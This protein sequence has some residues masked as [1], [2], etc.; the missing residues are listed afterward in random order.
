MAFTTFDTD[1]ENIQKLGDKP[2]DANGL[3]AYELKVLFDKAAV[4]LKAFI[5]TIMLPEIFDAV[6]AAARGVTQEGLSGTTIRDGTIYDSKLSKETGNQAVSTDTVQDKAITM[7]KLSSQIQTM[8]TNF[9]TAI[10]TISRTLDQKAAVSS[11]ATVATS[12]QYKDLSGTPTIP[13]IDSELSETSTNAVQNNLIFAALA[14]KA[15]IEALADVATSGQ[16]DDLSGK[17][18]IPVVDSALSTTSTNAVQNSLITN[19]LNKK[20]ATAVAKTVTLESGNT[21]WTKNVTGVT[22]SN[23]VLTAP[24]AGG[25]AQWVDH[26]VRCSGQGSGTLSFQADSATTGA[27]TVNIVI[28]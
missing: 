18:T 26:R 17:P 27:I 19:E 13:V 4:D 7:A 3:S 20:Q 12:G 28:L 1:V 21:S 24:D 22:T 23:I 15:N 9:Q 16:Y 11:L 8:L 6:D 25:Y 2:N 5:N 14:L 10:Q